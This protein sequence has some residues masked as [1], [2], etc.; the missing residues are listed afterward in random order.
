MKVSIIVPVY[1]VVSYI[2]KCIDSIFK[3]TYTNIE[4]I[5]IDDCGTDNSMD[6]IYNYLSI[7]KVCNY[8]ILH[9]QYN[10]GLSAA[11]NSGIQSATGDYIYFI[12]SDDYIYNECI[13][14]FVHLAEKYNYPD[15]I[16]GKNQVDPNNKTGLLTTPNN[17]F[18]EYKEYINNKHSINRFFLTYNAHLFTV[19]NRLIKLH[20]I[21]NNLNYFQEGIIYED[22]LWNWM[23]RKNIKTLAFNNNISYFYR[24]TPSSITK[25]YGKKE[26]ESENFILKEF[27]KNLDFTCFIPQIIYILRYSHTIYCRR[28]GSSENIIIRIIKCIILFI[29]N[30][31]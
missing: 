10:K 4:V 23:I 9:H 18:N 22:I 15:I 27:T 6:I 3:Q 25:R 13:E 26:I 12:D 20:I 11:R 8:K 31:H 1:N 29:K 19:W 16:I 21:K 2:Y 17:I 24:F 30:F 5:I 14:N 28:Y 7:N